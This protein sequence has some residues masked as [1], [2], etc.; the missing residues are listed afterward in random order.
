MHD[1]VGKVIYN[2]MCKRL[3]FDH[4]DKQYLHKTEFVQEN[5]AHKIILT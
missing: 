3:I 4:A 5:Q 1:W 2:E